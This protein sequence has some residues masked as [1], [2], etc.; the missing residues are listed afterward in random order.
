MKLGSGCEKSLVNAGPTNPLSGRFGDT[1]PVHETE[2]VVG[3]LQLLLLRDHVLRE[4][5]ERVLVAPEKLP[6][7]DFHEGLYL[8]QIHDG[9]HGQSQELHR[10]LALGCRALK[11]T[12]VLKRSECCAALLE[13][14]RKRPR[15]AGRVRRP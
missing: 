5:E 15:R 13:L 8:Q 2:F 1:H 12:K 14:R 10:V 9:G 7:G 3:Q 11:R 6:N 4:F